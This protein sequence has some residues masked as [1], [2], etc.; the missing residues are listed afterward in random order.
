MYDALCI[1]ASQVVKNP[2]A[3]ARDTRDMGSIPGSGRS[4]GGGYGNPFQYSYLENLM[5]RGPWR[6][7]V[8]RITKSWTRLKWHS[9]YHKR[10]LHSTPQKAADSF[11]L[12]CEDMITNE[13]REWSLWGIS[14]YHGGSDS[15][16]SVCNARDLGWIPGSGR[17]TGEVNGYPLQYSFLENPTDRGAQWVTVHG[18]AKSQTWMSTH[19]CIIILTNTPLLVWLKPCPNMHVTIFPS[20][21]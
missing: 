7:T 13:I 2:P 9:M 19:Y 5:D 16:Q 14:S 6:V 4:P 10:G 21:I 12:G 3:N 11:T 15:K 17:S 18:V 8:H 20:R 1:G